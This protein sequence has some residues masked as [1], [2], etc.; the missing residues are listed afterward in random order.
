[1]TLEDARKI[2]LENLTKG[3][4]CPCCGR[5]TKR[6]KYKLSKNVCRFMAVLRKIEKGTNRFVHVT[7]LLSVDPRILMSRDFLRAQFYDMIEEGSVENTEAK[8]R[9]GLWR[10]TDKGRSFISG[11]L[12]VPEYVTMYDGKVLGFEGEAK[13]VSDFD[14]EFFNYSELMR[15]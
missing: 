15:R 7:E 4:D 5:F 3:M 13:T 11:Q 6:Y 14:K 1:M 12:S 10:L 8:K 9:S 2:L